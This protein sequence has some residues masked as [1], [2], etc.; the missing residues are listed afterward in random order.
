MPN[1]VLVLLSVRHPTH[2]RHQCCSLARE[3]PELLRVEQG[4]QNHLVRRHPAP[5]VWKIAVLDRE[6]L[7]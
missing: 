6:V 1:Q 2:R 7:K 5:L 4:S 3:S